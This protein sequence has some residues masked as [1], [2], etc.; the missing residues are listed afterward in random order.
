MSATDSKTASS[1]TAMKKDSD[2]QHDLTMIKSEAVGE[3]IVIEQPFSL[4]S[5][6]GVAYS[7]TN[8]G[9]GILLSFGVVVTFGGPPAY[10]MLFP[11]HISHFRD[12]YRR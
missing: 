1:S 3:L 4:M 12:F 7:I 6:L 10:C 11:T 9:L 5:A 8:T 2:N